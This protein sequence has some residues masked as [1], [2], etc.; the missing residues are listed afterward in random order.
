MRSDW[1]IANV[2]R[3]M[4]WHQDGFTCISS[5]ELQLV[6]TLHGSIVLVSN[7]VQ[8]IEQFCDVVKPYAV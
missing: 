3:D 8:L 5:K 1:Y 6:L 2:F 4:L 7:F